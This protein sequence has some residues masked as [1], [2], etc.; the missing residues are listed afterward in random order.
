MEGLP[1]VEIILLLR[2]IVVE[3]RHRLGVR[4]LRVQG[5]ELRALRWAWRVPWGGFVPRA[6]P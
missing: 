4:E 6:M 3:S 1:R 5:M 2:E